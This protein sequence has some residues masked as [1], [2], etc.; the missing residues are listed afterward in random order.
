MENNESPKPQKK[1]YYEE[2]VER[3][4]NDEEQKAKWRREMQQSETLHSN[5]YL[6]V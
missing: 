5:F 4:K 1:N 6:A 3:V 2:Q